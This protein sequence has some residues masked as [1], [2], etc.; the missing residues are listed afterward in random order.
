MQSDL[1]KKIK[2]NSNGSGK[3]RAEK[4]FLN[5]MKIFEENNTELLGDYYG[6]EVVTTIRYEKLIFK[7]NIHNF[8]NQTIKRTRLLKS[9]CEENHDYFLCFSRK[10]ASVIFAKIKTFDGV[11]IELSSNNYGQFCSG[12]EKFYK[13]LEARGHRKKGHT[14][15]RVKRLVLILGVDVDF[16][17]IIHQTI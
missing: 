1:M 5:Y 8:V 12:R 2:I 7:S 3:I 6:K 13:T 9:K 15:E 10:E 14:W 11:I 17:L 16:Y 4:A